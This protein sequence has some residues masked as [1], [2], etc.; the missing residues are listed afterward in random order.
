MVESLFKSS[1]LTLVLIG[2]A[3]C[4]TVG[5]KDQLDLEC[6][7]IPVYRLPAGYSHTFEKQLLRSESTPEASWANQAPMILGPSD[8]PAES[9][10]EKVTYGGF[11]AQR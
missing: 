7:A 6:L 8:V 3:G 5:H 9:P 2:G 11:P 1:C 10:D 4:A